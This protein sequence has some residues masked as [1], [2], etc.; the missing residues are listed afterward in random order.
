MQF[1][2]FELYIAIS[3]VYYFFLLKTYLLSLDHS[4]LKVGG[5]VMQ[6]FGGHIW[7]QQRQ[8]YVDRP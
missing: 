1:S 8:I 4:P 5:G 7:T 2:R 6:H 3:K